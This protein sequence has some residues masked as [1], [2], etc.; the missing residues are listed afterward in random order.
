MAE[1]RKTSERKDVRALHR[2]QYKQAEI[3][4]LALLIRRVLGIKIIFII[5]NIME[6][7]I[8]ANRPSSS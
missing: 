4:L 7:P 8:N 3:F 1:L 2:S 6:V 5:V